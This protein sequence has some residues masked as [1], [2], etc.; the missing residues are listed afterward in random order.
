MQI[1]HNDILE[2][3]KYFSK[4]SHSKGRIRI[5]VSPKIMELRDSVSEESLKAKIA[6]IRGI[7]EYKFNALIGSL[8]IHYDENIFPMHLWDQ[9]LQGISSP[10]LVALV[11]SNIEAL[12]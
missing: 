7:K 10:E 5:R 3:H 8:T 11:N 1:D 6:A 4:I 9:F 2:F 12:S